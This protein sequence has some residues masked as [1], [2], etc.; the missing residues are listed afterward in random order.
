MEL[1]WFKRLVYQ[2]DQL[3][4]ETNEY[5]TVLQYRVFG[6]KRSSW[7]DVPLIIEK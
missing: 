1:R 7:Q 4:G 2:G 5:E 6:D 3:F